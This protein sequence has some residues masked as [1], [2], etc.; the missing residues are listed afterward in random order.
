[1]ENLEKTSGRNWKNLEKHCKQSGAI[2]KVYK[3]IEIYKKDGNK[4]EK[5][6][7][8]LYTLSK[9]L[10]RIWKIWS[11]DL[12]RKACPEYVAGHCSGK[13]SGGLFWN[14]FPGSLSGQLFLTAVPEKLSGNFTE[15]S[16]GRLFRKIVWKSCPGRCP[17][18]FFG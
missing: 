17:K 3:K 14:N 16:S 5:Y 6:G 1:M 18:M 8:E 2:W 15:D 12:F 9:N 4:L 13:L 11:A 7:N 10:E